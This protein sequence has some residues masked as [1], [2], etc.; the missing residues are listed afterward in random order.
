MNS[1]GRLI[2]STPAQ[3]PIMSLGWTPDS[4]SLVVACIGLFGGAVIGGGKG[5]FAVLA[6]ETGVPRS[7]GPDA[8]SFGAAPSPDGRLVAVAGASGKSTGIFGAEAGQPVFPPLALDAADAY[9]SPDGTR[10]ALL[11]KEPETAEGMIT[12]QLVRAGTGSLMWHHDVPVAR[13][14]RNLFNLD[15]LLVFS[16]DSHW[17]A[18][19][20][21]DGA[22]VFDAESGS[23]GGTLAEGG[24]ATKVAFSPDSRRVAAAGHDG[25]VR[26]FD[27]E[28]GQVVLSIPVGTTP[29]VSVAFS[30]DGRWLAAALSTGVGV[31]R[32][33]DGSPRFPTT[34]VALT[35]VTE[36]A[37]SPDLRHLAVGRAGEDP[38]VPGLTVLDVTSGELAWQQSTVRALHVAY[39]PDGRRLAAGGVGATNGTGVV[40]VHDTAVEQAKLVVPAAATRV[41][42]NSGG[43]QLVA[44]GTS[45]GTSD[46][47]F[48]FSGGD[49]PLE[50]PVPGALT[51]LAFSHDGQFLAAGST[52][53]IV[54][55]IP[56]LAADPPRKITHGGAV[57]AVAFGGA[58]GELVATASADKKARVSDLATLK[59]VCEFTHPNA[60]TQVLFGPDGSWIATG[61]ADR[62]TRIIDVPGGTER[63]RF[64][65]DGRVRALVRS[66]DGTLLAT[67]GDDRLVTLLDTATGESRGQI[68]HR[69]P[70]GAIAISANG[71]LIASAAAS[72]RSVLVAT[73][74]DLLA[75]QPAPP[76]SFGYGSPVTALA[77]HPVERLLAV[78][79][80]DDVVRLVDPDD[81]AEVLRLPHPAAVQDLAFSADGARLFT[82]C[83]DQA[84]RVFLTG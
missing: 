25:V 46:E 83:D 27:A 61:G 37:F 81:G 53:G 68:V 20:S 59:V 51:A 54:R 23:P 15:A 41:A 71:E 84:A 17:L 50:Q 62:C 16:P 31:F 38:T 75:G 24:G 26:I 4:A 21:P 5:A 72:D 40:V 14:D 56:T 18:V 1:P 76:R 2:S 7:F 52:D 34:L 44:V 66:P 30:P 19:A 48:V 22:N 33:D 55:L 3:T 78:V 39:S 49:D 70:V 13:S 6:A 9:Y 80:A 73:I 43:V 79:T 82:A 74:A 12:V 60:V 32:A 58:A 77:F 57:S 35:D 63:H 11:T 65:G 67:G 10:V 45:G 29:V 36:V 69:G 28:K 42:V 47:I 64:Q 8:P